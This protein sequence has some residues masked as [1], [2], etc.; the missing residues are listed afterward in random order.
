MDS[1]IASMMLDGVGS[2]VL[3]VL[4]IIALIV[5]GGFIIYLLAGLIISIIEKRNVKLFDDEAPKEVKKQE[6]KQEQL[7]LQDSSYELDLDEQDKKELE[8]KPVSLGEADKEKAEIE[9]NKASVEERQE[10]VEKDETEDE[11]DEDL[12]A[13]YQKLISDINESAKEDKTEPAQEKVEETVQEEEAE[14]EPEEQPTEEQ[15]TKENPEETEVE[16]EPKPVEETPAKQVEEP[17]EPAETEKDADLQKQINDLKAQLDAEK[18]QKDE[19]A[20]KLEEKPQVEVVETES[21]ESLQ[22]RLATLNQRLADS[23]KDLKANKKEYIPLSRI[24]RNLESDKAKLRRKE[25]VVAKQKVMLFG[26]NNY[27][28]DPE[29]EKKLSEDLDVLDA[30]RLSVQHCEEVMKENEDRYPILEKT[31]QI[32]T[33]QV[34]DLKNDVADVEAR[35]AKLQSSGTTGDAGDG[36]TTPDTPDTTSQN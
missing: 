6:Q 8:T 11:D 32:L 29:K 23:E 26:V 12:D 34:A 13:M 3:G 24:K 2:T 10:S 21:L 31:N 35:I 1:K 19:L 16:E 27:V 4:G 18:A 28:V 17:V 9:A 5:V 14:E 36:T 7:L 33:K 25:A 30:L 20:K 22:A 15:Q